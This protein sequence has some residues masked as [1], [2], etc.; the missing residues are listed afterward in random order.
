MEDFAP[1][2]AFSNAA[3]SGRFTGTPCASQL[4]SL[5]SSPRIVSLDCAMTWNSAFCSSEP[6]TASEPGPRA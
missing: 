1:P 2:A 4:P 6:R 5:Q 3:R